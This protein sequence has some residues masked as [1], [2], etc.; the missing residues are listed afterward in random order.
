MDTD[1]F[2]T[3]GSF[4]IGPLMGII[5]PFSK[6]T[7]RV[8]ATP[9][10]AAKEEFA[11]FEIHSDS[12]DAHKGQVVFRFACPYCVFVRFFNDGVP[13]KMFCCSFTLLGVTTC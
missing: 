5:Q 3:L 11:Y 8:N 2:V 6:V 4:S 9:S 12:A 13:A 10:E 7:L 1:E